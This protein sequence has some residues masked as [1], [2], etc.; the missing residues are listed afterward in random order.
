M[1]GSILLLDSDG[2]TLRHGS[3][4]SLPAGLIRLY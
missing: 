1:L 3:A 4:P 2:V